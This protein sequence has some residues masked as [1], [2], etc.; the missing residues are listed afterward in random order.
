MGFQRLVLH[1]I[2][3]LHHPV[4][5]QVLVDVVSHFTYLSIGEDI[6][7]LISALMTDQHSILGLSSGDYR[8]KMMKLKV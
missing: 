1:P 2:K 4:V 7:Y 8:L 6:V 5:C 3:V